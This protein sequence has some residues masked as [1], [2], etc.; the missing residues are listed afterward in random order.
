LQVVFVF[1]SGLT[2]RAWGNACCIA[3]LLCRRGPNVLPGS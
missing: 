2:M 1:V 3:L